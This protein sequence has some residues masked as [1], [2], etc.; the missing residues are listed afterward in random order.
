MA[1]R[2]EHQ[3]WIA[4]L[5][6]KLGDPTASVTYPGRAVTFS[7]PEQIIRALTYHRAEE[8]RLAREENLT[9]AGRGRSYRVMYGGRGY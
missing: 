7:T 1:T 8:A 2:T 3:E 6:R 9:L 4:A 5:E